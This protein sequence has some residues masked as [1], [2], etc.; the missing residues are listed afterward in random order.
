MTALT[1]AVIGLVVWAGVAT[2]YFSRILERIEDRIDGIDHNVLQIPKA[3]PTS[4]RPV[5]KGEQFT[6]AFVRPTG[7]DAPTFDSAYPLNATSDADHARIV[8]AKAE[9]TAKAQRRIDPT[10]S[11]E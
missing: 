4:P 10:W 8:A 1:L 9:H 3:W 2:I 5:R 11:P 7:T 6:V